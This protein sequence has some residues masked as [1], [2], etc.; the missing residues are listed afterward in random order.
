MLSWICN[1]FVSHSRNMDSPDNPTTVAA[2]SEEMRKMSEVA[3]GEQLMY[4]PDML[5]IAMGEWKKNPYL[6]NL[7]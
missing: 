1:K 7:K 2:A 4:D 6:N 3:S 5:V